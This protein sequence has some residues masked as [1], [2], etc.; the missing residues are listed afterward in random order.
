MNNS[1]QA[2]NAGSLIRYKDGEETIISPPPP[3]PTDP[4]SI[5]YNFLNSNHNVSI[6]PAAGGAYGG[7]GH[8]AVNEGVVCDWSNT[9]FIGFT[10]DL[11]SEITRVWRVTFYFTGTVGGGG[12]QAGVGVNGQNYSGSLE[13]PSIGEYKY[14]ILLS[15]INITTMSLYMSSSYNYKLISVVFDRNS[16][17]CYSFD[18][19]QSNG[20][21]EQWL[22]QGGLYVNGLGWRDI[23]RTNNT[24]G[25]E[26]IRYFSPSIITEITAT[27]VS[28]NIFGGN[29][30][31][32]T[33]PGGWYSVDT[34]NSGTNIYAHPGLY[35][36]GITS[37]LFNAAAASA[38]SIVCTNV[39]L[40][41]L[42]VNPFG[43]SNC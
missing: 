27:I 1:F 14:T 36:S 32:G 39:T 15:D 28:T 41:G 21:W 40:K 11:P 3:E 12:F 37:V 5:S 25:F 23:T 2:F 19:T 22:G 31:V 18:F 30:Y 17:W 38:E 43:S 42:R 7:F 13:N 6:W 24:K 29:I 20:G 9:C 35:L 33:D 10:W 4:A 8:W 16:S 26:I 34:Q